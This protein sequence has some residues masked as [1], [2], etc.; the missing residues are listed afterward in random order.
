MTQENRY[1]MPQSREDVAVYLPY[2]DDLAVLGTPVSIGGITVPNRF[3][4]QPMEGCDG[5]AFGSPDTLTRRRYLRFASGGAG[6]IWFEATAVMREGRANPRQI[7]IDKSNLDDFKRLIVEVKETCLREN[8]Y[9]PVVICQLTHS[10]RYAKPTGAPAPLIAYNNP[11]FEKD[12]PISKA[13]VVSD[14]YLDSVCEH[15]VNGAALA[16]AAGFDGADIK[17]C[18]RYLLSELLSAYTREGRYGGSFENRTRLFTTAVREALRS[19]AD[20]TFIVTS[21]YNVYDGFPYPYGFGVTAETGLTPVL[22]EAL[23]L[24]EML[25]SSGM[26]LFNVTMGNP[27]VNPEVNRPTPF[28][29]SNPYESTVRILGGAEAVQRRLP[30]A[31]VISSGLSFLGVTA[32]NV[33]AACINEGRFA[34]AGFGRETLAYPNIARDILKN[35]AFDKTKTCLACGKCTEVM[36]SG[37]TPGCVVRDT[38][39]Y[40]PL[41]REVLAERTQK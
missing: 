31:K 41:Y 9:E 26:R 39:I 2:T 24:S 21:R 10:G 36:R 25:Y 30:D 29:V 1:R 8:G 37:R 32:P 35:G 28:G 16:K 23:R 17:S 11:I 27:Y 7:Y 22:D 20:E 14:E 38:E 4:Y 15:L 6:L 34:F 18:H 3:V 40:L 19:T 5:T 13:A 33:A 12:K